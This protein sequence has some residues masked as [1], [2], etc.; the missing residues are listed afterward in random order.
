MSSFSATGHSQDQR[1]QLPLPLSETGIFHLQ[2]SSLKPPTKSLAITSS[3]IVKTEV[4]RGEQ[5]RRTA[6]LFGSVS[7]AVF[8]LF[9]LRR[10]EM[11]SSF[12]RSFLP[13]MLCIPSERDLAS[14][15]L[16]P[17]LSLSLVCFQPQPLPMSGKVLLGELLPLLGALNF[18]HSDSYSPLRYL[19]TCYFLQKPFLTLTCK[20]DSL[21]SICHNHPL[22]L[23]HS[24]ACNLE[25]SIYWWGYVCLSPL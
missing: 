4:L 14:A 18:C 24:T 21:I 8:L 9:H 17:H 20:S 22:F 23:S 7:A 12:G 15:I 5:P 10:E 16:G 6:D 2:V 19:L 25:P 13:M 3:F 1:S 11:S